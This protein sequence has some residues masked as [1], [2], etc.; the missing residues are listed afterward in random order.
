MSPYTPFRVS[1][2]IVCDADALRGRLD[3]DG[4]LFFRGAGPKEKLAAARRD[5]FAILADAGWIDRR[6]SDVDRGVARWS[7]TVGPL[8]EGDP[9][10]MAVYRKIINAPS[11]LAVPE[12]PFFMQLMGH[13]VGGEAL[14]HRLRIGRI[15]FPSN[16]AQT[17]PAHQDW[18]YIRGAAE[19]YT[20]WQPLVDC[21]IELGPLAV[22]AGSHRAGF[23]SHR[24]D[25]SMKFA[26]M[27]LQDDQLP[28][29]QWVTG[30]FAAGDLV[31]F[32]SHTVHKALPNITPDR[33]RISTDNRYQR[34]GAETSA[35]SAGTHYDL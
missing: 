22:L 35:V 25:K 7:G 4:Y 18:H 27:G 5:V 8:T 12:D 17:T 31:L 24:E 28:P 21:P 15:V 10:Y 1:N 32:H 20:V 13:I 33:L 34:V 9:A 23:I 26:S 14:C 3:Y 16:T 30:D 29:G 2:D 11:F 19:T 6:G